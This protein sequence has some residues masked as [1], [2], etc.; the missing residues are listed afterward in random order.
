MFSARK[1]LPDLLLLF[2]NLNQY[3]LET[4]LEYLV[5]DCL[6]SKIEFESQSTKFDR[7]QKELANDLS[8]LFNMLKC[9][10]Y[11]EGEISLCDILVTRSAINILRLDFCFVSNIFE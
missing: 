10:F 9:Q 7:W 6:T 5:K 1:I 3:V 2:P 4:I 11:A 8:K